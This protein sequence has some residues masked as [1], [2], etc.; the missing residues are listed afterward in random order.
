L[1]SAKRK[2]ATPAAANPRP[3]WYGD[4]RWRYEDD[5]LVIET[6]GFNDKTFADETYNAPHTTKLHDPL[7]TLQF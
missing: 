3:L 6:I 1:R 4:F 2:L 5:E 7:T